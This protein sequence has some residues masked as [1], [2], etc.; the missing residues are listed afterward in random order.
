LDPSI[1]YFIP[2]EDWAV[3]IWWTV[4]QAVAIPVWAYF[5]RVS[6]VRLALCAKPRRAEYG[7]PRSVNLSIN[8]TEPT[9]RNILLTG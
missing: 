2:F 9:E 3:G 7:D 8:F 5:P 4:E 6:N 1:L